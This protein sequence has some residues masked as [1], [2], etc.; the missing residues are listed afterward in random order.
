I[1]HHRRRIIEPA[2]E[3]LT[4]KSLNSLFLPGGVILLGS[5][6]LLDTKWIAL[7]QSGVT[8]FYYAAFVAAGLLAWRFHSTRILFSVVVLLIGH[9]AVQFYA[10]RDRKSTRLNSSHV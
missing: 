6:L 9:H 10:Q 7:S 8:F 2:M 4:K 5:I 3:L 1:G